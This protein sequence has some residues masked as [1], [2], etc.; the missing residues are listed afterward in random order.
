MKEKAGNADESTMPKELGTA[1]VGGCA[2]SASWDGETSA[3]S[4]EGIAANPA[5]VG[6][7]C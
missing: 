2:D 7:L 1:G 5:S 6:M 4:A 3:T